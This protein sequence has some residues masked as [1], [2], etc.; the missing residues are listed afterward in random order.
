MLKHEDKLTS[1]DQKQY[2]N[3]LNKFFAR[4]KPRIADDYMKKFCTPNFL[5]FPITF[6]IIFACVT[7]CTPIFVQK[8]RPNQGGPALHP[9]VRK[10][11]QK[12]HL[13]LAQPSTQSNRKPFSALNFATLLFFSWSAWGF[14]TKYKRVQTIQNG[15]IEIAKVTKIKKYGAYRNGIAIYKINLSLL[16]TQKQ[17]K[18]HCYLRGEVINY[19]YDIF[20]SSNDNALD[21][22]YDNH[23]EVILPLALILS[24]RYY[25]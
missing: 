15:N 12:Q 10:E 18:C 24:R 7:F 22:I 21:V 16:N 11:L 25:K 20:E 23:R 3:F 8:N 17:V 13:Q 5:W 2:Y 1:D 6:A 4:P 14:F 9:L 19:F